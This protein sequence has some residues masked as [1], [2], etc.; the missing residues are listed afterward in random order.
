M[1][2]QRA[3]RVRAAKS[4]C[5]NGRPDAV[6]LV[7]MAAQKPIRIVPL[8]IEAAAPV[9]TP[10]LT[11]RGGPLL[12]TAQVFVLFWCD[13]WRQDPLTSHVQQLNNFYDYVLTI[14]P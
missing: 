11:Y 14:T 4:F 5:K 3:D 10:Q 7:G 1:R 6:K 8:S 9:G 2:R 13:D 12:A